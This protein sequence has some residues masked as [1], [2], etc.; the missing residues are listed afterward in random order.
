MFF[1]QSFQVFNS[2][3]ILSLG[4]LTFTYVFKQQFDFGSLH[5]V[6]QIMLYLS[7]QQFGI[8][9]WDYLCA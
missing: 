4:F 3:Q 8:S 6:R 1:L 2:F 5:Q 9:N 7:V